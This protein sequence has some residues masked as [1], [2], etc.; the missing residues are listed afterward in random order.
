MR[1]APLLLLLALAG[2]APRVRE[3]VAHKHY[4]EAVCAAHDGGAQRR[5]LVSEALAADTDAYV[6]VHRVDAAEL[7]AQVGDPTLAHDVLARVYIARISVQAN[8]LP[9]DDLGLAVTIAGDDMA[10]A[11]APV[12]WETLAVATGETVPAPERHHTYATVGNFLRGLGVVAT[13]GLSLPY[14]RFKPRA[15][16]LAA[17]TSAYERQMPRAATLLR[18]LGPVR[19]DGVG[20]SARPQGVACTGHFVFDRSPDARWSLT[21]AQTYVAATDPAHP[22]D[23]ASCTHDRAARVEIGRIDEWPAIFGSRMRRL[24]D[25]PAG[26]VTLAWSRVDPSA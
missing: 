6:H 10:A 21:L 26:P 19:C 14:T 11:A 25:L 9:L 13:G 18:A 4:R 1:R 2:C 23:A 7:A 20:L 24:V 5:R 17:P 3:L 8:T 16:T 22:T 15:Y 12:G